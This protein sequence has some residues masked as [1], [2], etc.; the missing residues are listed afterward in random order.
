MAHDFSVL[1]EVLPE[2]FLIGLVD[3]Q[4][5]CLPKDALLELIQRKILPQDR[6]KLIRFGNKYT[7][8]F[9]VKKIME[10]CHE[11]DKGISI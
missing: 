7:Y 6:E 8:S 5:E 2:S 11:H 4:S 1:Q 10:L 9:R 3:P